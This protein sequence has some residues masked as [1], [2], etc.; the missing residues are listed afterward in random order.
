MGLLLLLGVFQPLVQTSSSR[1]LVF[2]LSPESD[3]LQVVAWL[4]GL[5]LAFDPVKFG[6]PAS[7]DESANII[8]ERFPNCEKDFIVVFRG[9]TRSFKDG[10]VFGRVVSS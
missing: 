8:L 3:A 6:S 9:A 7:N 10:I 4:W 1:L 5:D 2:P